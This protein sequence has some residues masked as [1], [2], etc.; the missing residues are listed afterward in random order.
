MTQCSGL[1]EYFLLFLSINSSVIK[2]YCFVYV[3]CPVK[4]W[5]EI[6]KTTIAVINFSYL[7]HYLHIYV[8]PSLSYKLTHIY[9]TLWFNLTNV[10]IFYMLMFI[11]HI[12]TYLHT[13]TFDALKKY[14]NIFFFPTNESNRETIYN[15][16]HS[17]IL[18]HTKTI[19]TQFIF[20]MIRVSLN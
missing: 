19:A 12:R 18:R 16:K 14:K 17:S 15:D 11:S 5:I 1:K 10:H 13:A 2:I 4:R 7:M 6:H 3:E 20:Y 9:L 8:N